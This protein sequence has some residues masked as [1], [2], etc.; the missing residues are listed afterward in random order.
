MSYQKAWKSKECALENLMGSTEESYAKLARYC[1]NMEKTNPSS[2]FFIE[3][4]VENC[5]KFFFMA[6]GQYIRGFRNAIVDNENDLS[7]HWF[8]TK[9]REV[10][11]EV[12]DL[13]F[14]TDQGQYCMYHIQGNL[15]IRYRGK[16]IVS[17]IRRVTEAYSIE[18]YNRT[19]IQH[20]DVKQ[21]GVSNALFKRDRE[22]PILTL[23][24]IIRAKLQQWFNDRLAESHNCTSMLAPAKEVKL[25]KA[26]E[27]RR[28]LNVKSL[29]ESRFFVEC[30][31]HTTYMFESFPCEHA[32][33]VAM[34]RG[35]TARTLYYPYYI[36][37]NWRAAYVE[38][39][40]Q[41]PNEAEW[42]VAD[43]IRPFNTLSPPLIEPR[44]LGRPSTFKI[45]STKE[46]RRPHRCSRC[47]SVGHTH[48]FC[49]SQVSLNDS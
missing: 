10:I 20:D 38:T 26:A 33:T 17:L 11:G 21:R 23:I 22:L 37:E 8:F 44:D 24:E 31:H 19:S 7:M 40:F 43:H 14:V 5:F 46:F 48:Q 45:P 30:A 47:K 12:E 3:M 34:Y 28:K 41:F 29:D 25:F 27:A 39:I 16:S 49:T 1:H 36:A 4:E 32:V 9:L 42:E 6:L 18:E 35:F 13:A 2:A 15:K